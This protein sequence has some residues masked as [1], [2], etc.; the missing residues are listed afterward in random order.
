MAVVQASMKKRQVIASSNRTMFLWITIASAVIGVCVV[1]GYFLVRQ[2]IY[3][4]EVAASVE[5]TSTVLKQNNVD[6][7]KLVEN[8]R[9]LDTNNALNSV[10]ARSEDRALQV[11]LDALPADVNT[12]ALGASLQQSILAGVQGIKVDGLSIDSSDMIVDSTAAISDTGAVTELGIIPFQL[13]VSAGEVGAFTDLLNRMERSIRTFDID[14]LSFEAT[15]ST[16]TMT[17]TAHAYY[18]VGKE[19]TLANEVKKP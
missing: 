6:A 11:V 15:S 17:M 9:V 13:S 19:V 5:T 8:V 18:L 2:I 12:L 10:K 14:T 1:V 4:A 7:K 3:R 16:Y